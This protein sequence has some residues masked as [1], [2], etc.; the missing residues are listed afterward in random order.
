[1]DRRIR[2]GLATTFAVAAGV[3]AAPVPAG[4]ASGGTFAPARYLATGSTATN[5]VAVA[6]VTGDGRQDI[7]VGIDAAD[8]TQT[9]SV[10]VYAQ[11]AGG[12][13]AALPKITAHGGYNSNVRL[14]VADIDADG[15]TDVALS[16]SAG[17]DV[18]YQRNGRLAAP[19]LAAGRGEDVAIADVTGDGRP[20]LVVARVQGE[21]RIYPQTSSHTFPTYTTV[22]GPYTAGV[23]VDQV[24]VADLNADGRPD[25]AQFYGHGTWVRLRRADG[26]YA[27]A[28]TYRAPADANGYRPVGLAATVGDVT[29]DGRADL[30]TSVNGNSP[31]AA[32]QVFA[33]GTGGLAATPASYPTY[34]CPAGLAIGDLTGDG[35]QD[36]V[37][38]HGSWRAVSVRL[39]Q[40]DGTLGA[41]ATNLVDGVGSQPD[42]LAVGDVTGD[43][44]PDVVAVAYD[45]VA[46]LR[47]L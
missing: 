8:G 5:A 23:P 7:V 12:T 18:L 28:T 16:S 19:V 24:F 36:L 31:D 33:Q 21:V 41:Y 15:R 30:V 9:S 22:T 34:D 44:K 35:R 47:Q 46:V 39:Q 6:D 29:G 20:D 10:L 4:A 2:A 42:A 40:S 13:Y 26:S 27:A 32:V 1:M 43:G 25:L 17:I 45:K 37:V 3:T 11:Q 14:A 38:A